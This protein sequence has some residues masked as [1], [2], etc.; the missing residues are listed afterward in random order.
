MKEQILHKGFYHI[1]S[2]SINETILYLINSIKIKEMKEWSRS[3]L[4]I[5][6]CILKL[7]TFNIL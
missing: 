6:Y 5:I 7:L 1:N 2:C 4:T 3:P